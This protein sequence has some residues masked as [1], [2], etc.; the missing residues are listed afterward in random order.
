MQELKKIRYKFMRERVNS[1]VSLLIGLD[2]A[3]DMLE[4]LPVLVM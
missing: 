3:E 2:P 1:R 4:K